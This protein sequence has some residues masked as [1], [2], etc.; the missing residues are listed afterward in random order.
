MICTHWEKSGF[1]WM[2]TLT[3]INS[4]AQDLVISERRLC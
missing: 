2:C 4:D 3:E 1:L